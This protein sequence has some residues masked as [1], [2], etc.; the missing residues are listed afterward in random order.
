MPYVLQDPAEELDY[1]VDWSEVLDDVGS[2]SDTI[3][4]S[5]WRIEPEQAGSP[6][7]ETIS[8]E[9]ITSNV[10]NCL[11][12]GLDP[13]VK[14]YHLINTITTAEGR[15]FERSQTIRCQNR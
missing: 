13:A 12:S 11:V 8:S 1:P 7:A 4:T 6:S 10:T 14:L 3:A 9:T 5:A 15:I 2:P